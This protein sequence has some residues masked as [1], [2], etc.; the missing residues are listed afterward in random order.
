[1]SLARRYD[2]EDIAGRFGAASEQE[3]NCGIYCFV[4]T[5]CQHKSR[6]I[7]MRAEPL[8]FTPDYRSLGAGLDRLCV[9]RWFAHAKVALAT[10]EHE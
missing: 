6:P 4:V 10:V 8:G 2:S 1:V 3:A 7:L 5:I 9:V